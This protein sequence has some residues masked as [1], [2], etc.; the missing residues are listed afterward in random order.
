[1]IVNVN[2]IV[3]QVIQIKNGIVINVN[4]SVQVIL[5]AKKIIF[6]NPSICV[7]ENCKFLKSIAD[8][9]VIACDYK[10]NG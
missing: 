9:S 4:I 2:S 7:C 5:G 3:Q 1:M 8:A 10:C 6:W